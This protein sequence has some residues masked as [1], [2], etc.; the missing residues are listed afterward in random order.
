MVHFEVPSSGTVCVPPD[1]WTG[2]WVRQPSFRE[3]ADCNYFDVNDSVA[4][5]EINGKQV[6]PIEL[7]ELRA[8]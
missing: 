2:T 3:L 6:F 7:A 4:A 8:D 1:R 5:G